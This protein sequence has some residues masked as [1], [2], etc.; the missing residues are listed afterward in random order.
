[1]HHR[2]QGGQRLLGAELLLHLL[3]DV[4]LRQ[5]LL[6]HHLTLSLGFNGIEA[7]AL[8]DRLELSHFE[9]FPSQ[10]ELKVGIRDLGDKRFRIK[11]LVGGTIS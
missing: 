11:S 4:R 9:I 10:P 7:A 3:Q 8:N 5:G 6:V 1:L 2:H